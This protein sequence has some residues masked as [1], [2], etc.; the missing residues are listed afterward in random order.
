MLI[1]GIVIG[2]VL[3]VIGVAVAYDLRARHLR[4][5][6]ADFRESGR[7]NSRRAAREREAAEARGRST[8]L[9]DGPSG[10]FGPSMGP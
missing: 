2:V 3:V 10:G 6:S 5:L 7:L 1:L 4:A 8:N 9:G